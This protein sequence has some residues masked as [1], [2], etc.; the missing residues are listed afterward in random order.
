MTAV[1]NALNS[2][3]HR[4][5]IQ[6]RQKERS[7]AQ[8]LFWQQC[9]WNSSV[10]EELGSL[11]AMDCSSSSVGTCSQ[12]LSG[13]PWA[14]P[15]I[16]EKC[17]RRE[18][19]PSIF[20]FVKMPACFCQYPFISA[21]ICPSLPLSACARQYAFRCFLKFSSCG[22]CGGHCAEQVFSAWRFLRRTQNR[23]RV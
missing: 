11:E 1:T 10:W 4:R 23:V 3:L 6:P 5:V 19:S 2:T 21:Y 7:S 17:V 15:Q 12:E 22:I 8:F 13:N 18:T 16:P 14:V 9:F 20:V